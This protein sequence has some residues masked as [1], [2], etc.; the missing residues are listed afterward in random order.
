LR[1]IKRV[2]TAIAVLLIVICAAGPL[3]AGARIY[4]RNSLTSRHITPKGAHVALIPPSGGTPSAEFI[5][6]EIQSR[7]IEYRIIERMTPY[8]S[9]EGLLTKEALEADGIIAEDISPVNLNERPATLIIGKVKDKQGDED[10]AEKTAVVLFVLGNERLT[11]SIYG[12]YPAGDKSAASMLRNSVLTA[13]LEPNKKS[14][15]IG[16]YSILAN[17]TSLKL[18]DEV[19]STK[20]FTIDGNPPSD[21]VAAAIFTSTKLQ[22][23]VPDGERANF[24]DKSMERYLS[25]YEFT[26]TSRR[27]VTL[28]GL[29]GIEI[30]AEFP[31][32]ERRDRTAS[33]GIVTRTRTA[34]AYQTTLFGNDGSIYSFSGIT[35]TD[36]DSY[37]QQFRKITSTFKLTK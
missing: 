22:Q 2:S 32:A 16:G 9:S 35:V 23:D 29:R 8:K 11:I 33:G 7:G 19:S 36:V 5:G 27:D 24:A 25:S 30:V 34:K 21:N 14:D 20:Y 3:E 17:G 28:G 4:R 26:I 1:K 18:Y 37:I 15:S 6:F 12:Y 13:V 31:G 10:P